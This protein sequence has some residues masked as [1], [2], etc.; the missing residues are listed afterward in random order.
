MKT[1]PLYPASLLIA[2]VALLA[3]PQASADLVVIIDSSFANGNGSFEFDSA[4]A[5]LTGSIGTPGGWVGAGALT[6][7]GGADTIAATT[8]VN[9]TNNF[10]TD[11]T[12]SL[13]VHPNEGAI[14]PIGGILDTGYTLGLGDELN[15]SFDWIKTNNVLGEAN[16]DLFVFTSSDNTLGGTLTS[17]AIGT[18]GSG[19]ATP[20]PLSVSLGPGD[21]TIDSASVGQNLFLAFA[22]GGATGQS[23]S[24]R[25]NIDNISFTAATAVPEPSSLALFGLGIVGFA[26]KRRRAKVSV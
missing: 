15:L 2:A 23:S 4:G 16:F 17:L 11:G 22:A 10:S 19:P 20:D 18:F 13:Q 24:S 7:D 8:N 9:A 14:A 21:F 12:F 25:L 3:P 6:I 5:P 1:R 26:A